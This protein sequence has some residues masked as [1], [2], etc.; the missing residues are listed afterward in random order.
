MTLLLSPPSVPTTALHCCL[1]LTSWG[2]GATTEDAGHAAHECGL[3]TACSTTQMYVSRC[4]DVLRASRTT[5]CCIGPT[6]A[7]PTI[8]CEFC[9]HLTTYRYQQPDR[10]RRSCH[11]WRSPQGRAWTRQPAGNTR[12]TE[13]GSGS[14]CCTDPVCH[15]SPPSC[16]SCCICA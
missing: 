5:S 16:R 13:S 12:G 10:Q 9:C 7:A 2:L 14:A 3:A 1:T 6:I 11:P 4:C 15:I 8:C